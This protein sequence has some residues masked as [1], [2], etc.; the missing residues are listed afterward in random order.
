MRANE[1]SKTFKSLLKIEHKLQP[2]IGKLQINLMTPRLKTVLN[3]NIKTTETIKIK[4]CLHSKIYLHLDW[5][6]AQ[7][8]QILLKDLENS[9]KTRIDLMKEE[10]KNSE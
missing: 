6:I 5:T 10:A 3:P 4:G 2:E 9:L 1:H 8:T 7:F